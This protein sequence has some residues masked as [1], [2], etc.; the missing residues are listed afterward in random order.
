MSGG[1]EVYTPIRFDLGILVDNMRLPN[2]FSDLNFGPIAIQLCLDTLRKINNSDSS[3]MYTCIVNKN[4]TFFFNINFQNKLE[5][6]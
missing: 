6:S 2:K 1:I 4:Y 5:R 3:D